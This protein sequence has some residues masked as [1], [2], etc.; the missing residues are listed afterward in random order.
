MDKV[1]WILFTLIL[2]ELIFP[3]ISLC[4][5]LFFEIIYIKGSSKGRMMKL[6]QCLCNL[7]DK[8]HTVYKEEAFAPN[9]QQ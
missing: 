3:S 9:M 8:L 1:L 5:T 4:G 2:Y 6:I 7:I